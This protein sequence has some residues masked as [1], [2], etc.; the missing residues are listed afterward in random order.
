[1][2]NSVPEI[3]AHRIRAI[4]EWL[5]DHRNVLDPLAA[6][7]LGIICAL[8][9]Q[10]RSLPTR[11]ALAE[12]LGCNIFSIDGAISKAFAEDEI[13]EEHHRRWGS[14]ATSIRRGR[15]LLPSQQLYDAYGAAPRDPPGSPPCLSI[16]PPAD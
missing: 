15:Y 14:E 4:E 5:A 1:M 7:L 3:P 16:V 6:P 9:E 12:V 10:Q 8:Y 13:S 11:R 2:D